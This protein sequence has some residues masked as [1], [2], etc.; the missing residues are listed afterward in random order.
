[1]IQSNKVRKYAI[2]TSIDGAGHI[3]LL[4]H[5]MRKSSFKKTLF[6]YLLMMGDCL[7]LVML[8]IACT[9]SV[10]SS[11]E[12][13]NGNDASLQIC[14]EDPWSIPCNQIVDAG[15]SKDGIPSIDSP[16]FSPISEIDFLDD[17]ELVLA[18]KIGNDVRAYPNVIL[19]YHEIVNDKVKDVPIAITYCPL[20]GS[21]IAWERTL[22]DTITTFGVSG[23]IHKNNLIAYDRKTNSNWSQMLNKS[24]S[25]PFKGTETQTVQ[26]VEMT[27]GTFKEAFPDAK[28]LNKNTGYDRNY[29]LYLY[30]AD[31]PE[32]N[33]RILFPIYNEDPRFEKKTLVHGIKYDPESKVYPIDSF[34]SNLQVTHDI[35]AGKG[36][37]VVGSSNMGMV[38]SFERTLA[39]GTELE[40]KP[41]EGNLP[42]VMEDQEGTRWNIF[43]EAVSGPRQG[44]KLV[45]TPNFNAYWFAWADFF[46]NVKV[47]SGGI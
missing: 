14:E 44:Q 43:G 45:A 15:A 34:S 9:S 7:L 26:L 27:W 46:R 40:F 12:I 47:G 1:M 31:Y 6:F 39:D 13:T 36:V 10:D 33:D 18:I 29:D 5:Y 11:G 2:V 41:V 25:G 35:V 28:V 21:G 42:I 19:Y 16:Q 3:H 24:V 22:D 32:D 20:T 4:Q 38:I 8:L 23:L 37:V 30:G 17:W